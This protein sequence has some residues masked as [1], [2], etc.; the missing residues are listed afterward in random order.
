MKEKLQK[1]L[2]FLKPWWGRLIASA[3]IGLLPAL[4]AL[5]L[6]DI[7]Y[8]KNDNASIGWL[9]GAGIA[10]IGLYFFSAWLYSSSDTKQ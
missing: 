2:R 3:I 4:I 6:T 9:V 1:D 8:K 5:S 7:Y 10:F